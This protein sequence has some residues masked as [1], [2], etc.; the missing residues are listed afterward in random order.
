MKNKKLVDVFLIL[1]IIF[2]IIGIGINLR[3]Q[4][5]PKVEIIKSTQTTK[6]TNNGLVNINT[7]DLAQLDTLPG[8]GPATAQ[9]IIDYRLVHNGF[10]SIN[11]INNVSGIG[12]KKYADIAPKI[13]I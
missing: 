6:P 2:I 12:P 13:S 3:E 4:E 1:G 10:K 11:E 5:K 7:A 9:K 8:I